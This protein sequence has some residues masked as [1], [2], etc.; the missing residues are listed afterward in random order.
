MRRYRTLQSLGDNFLSLAARPAEAQNL[1]LN[2]A[3]PG[4]CCPSQTNTG[5]EGGW[6]RR[7]MGFP[8]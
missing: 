3:K 2:Q 1:A 6:G 4:F 7:G 8:S 5:R